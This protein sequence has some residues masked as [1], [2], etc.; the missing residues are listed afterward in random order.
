[1]DGLVAARLRG[2]VRRWGGERCGEEGSEAGGVERLRAQSGDYRT[3]RPR[4]PCWA[5]TESIVCTCETLSERS[6][7]MSFICV[8]IGLECR[9]GGGG[10]G[11]G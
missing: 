4:L 9:L 7:G 1:M 5:G 3:L 6:I 2:A 8:V 10:G 11:A